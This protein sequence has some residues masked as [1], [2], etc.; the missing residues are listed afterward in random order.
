LVSRRV[1]GVGMAEMPPTFPAAFVCGLSRRKIIG[2]YAMMTW[3][4][5]FWLAAPVVLLT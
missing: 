2:C 4:E 3:L 5:A 1:G